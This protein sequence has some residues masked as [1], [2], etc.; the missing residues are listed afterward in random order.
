MIYEHAHLSLRFQEPKRLL[1]AGCKV[2]SQHDEDGIIEEIFARIG[3]TDR[4]FVEFGV[5]DGTEN[6]TLYLLLKG[7][8]GAWMDGSAACVAAARRHLGFLMKNGRLRVREAFI[9][10]ENIE[11]LF[12]EER[13]PQEFDFL[14]I[15]VDRN[16]FWI[17]KALHHYR[18]RVVAVEYNGTFKSTVSCVVPYEGAAIWDGSN[19][20]G[21]SLK[22]LEYLGAG[23]GYSL[24][25][26]NYTGVTAFFVRDDCL[27]SLF[28]EPYTSENHYEPPRYFIRMPNGHRPNFGPL[29][30]IGPRGESVSDPIR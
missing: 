19:Y 22:A 5:G 16:D 27:G 30:A 26:C 11:Q 29:V 3:T 2:Y 15:D 12:A 7:W 25:G 20:T 23:R 4:F 6:C 1:R 21:C 28:A 17:W 13:V 10:A 8:S 9:T 24:V 14:S 18:P